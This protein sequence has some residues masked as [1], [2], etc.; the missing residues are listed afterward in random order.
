MVDAS[1]ERYNRGMWIRHGVG[2]L[3]LCAAVLAQTPSASCPSDRPVDE[4][5]AEIQK[6][7]SKKASRNRNPL[8]DNMCIA[9]WCRRSAKTPPIIRDPAPTADV[10]QPTGEMSS[11]RPVVNKCDDAMERTLTAAHDVEVGDYYF[12]E[13]NYKAASFRYEDALKNKSEDAAIHVRLGRANE[14]LKNTARALEEYQ[15]AAKL[16]GPEKWIEEARSG[17]ARLQR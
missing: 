12:A 8:P 1:H 3:V 15:I 11:S 2:V 17:V 14:K 6:Q 9:G 16:S 10:M 4:I 7:Q 13:K 5:I